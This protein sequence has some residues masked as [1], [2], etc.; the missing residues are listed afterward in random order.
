MASY[1]GFDDG[2]IYDEINL[3]FDRRRIPFIQLNP[4]KGVLP[5]REWD[6]K[7]SRIDY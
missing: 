7:E 4:E 1:H 6:K 5:F 2:F 3:S